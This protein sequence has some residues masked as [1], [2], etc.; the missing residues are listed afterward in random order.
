MLILG[1]KAGPPGGSRAP[2][3]TGQGLLSGFCTVGP[4]G[5]CLWDAVQA[6]PPLLGLCPGA[7][8]EAS[9]VAFELVLSSMSSGFPQGPM[10]RQ[11]QA[12]FLGPVAMWL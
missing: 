11:P 12:C 4:A 6:I 8:S 3:T 9:A 1:P 7:F 2:P 10:R 5:N